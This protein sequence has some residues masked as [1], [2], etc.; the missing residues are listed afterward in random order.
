MPPGAG[1]FLPMRKTCCNLQEAFYHKRIS[2]A[3][4]KINSMI[5]EKYFEGTSRQQFT[6]KSCS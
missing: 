5:T 4:R 1:A 2:A 6:K 3:S